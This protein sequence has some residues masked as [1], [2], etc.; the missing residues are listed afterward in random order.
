MKNATNEQIKNIFQRI[1]SSE[2]SLNQTEK[3]HA[4]YGDSEF[5]LFAKQ[6]IEESNDLDFD[7]ISYKIDKDNRELLHNFFV[8]DSGIFTSNDLDR[9]LALQYIMTLLSTMIEGEYFN[10]VSKNERY[11]A[12]Y[13]GEFESAYMY[14]ESL[15]EIVSFIN[16]LNIKND[17][18][19]FTKYSMFTLII[20]LHKFINKNKYDSFSK[21]NKEYFLRELN[22][23]DKR[24]HLYFSDKDNY[25]EINDGE[26]LYFQGSRQ[27]V[28]DAEPRENRGKVVSKIICDS[29][30]V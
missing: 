11:L 12:N 24:Y 25:K 5:M 15:V 10:R 27:G 14:E 6:I 20:E 30:N 13:N 26:I 28:N 3:Y 23:L 29:T 22:Y 4:Q 16:S 2:Y 1:N 18:I 19:W 9:M 7:I 21:I 8:Q 17:T